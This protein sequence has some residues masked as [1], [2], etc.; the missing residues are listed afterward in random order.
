MNTSS[1]NQPTFRIREA[2]RSDLR[3]LVALER[4]LFGPGAWPYDV[5]DSELHADGRHY[6]VATERGIGPVGVED[7][8]RVIGYGGIAISDVGEIM[9]IGVTA[10]AQGRG[11][12]R[13]LTRALIEAAKA[14]GV[15]EVFLE[16]RVDNS[17]AINL[18][19]SLGFTDVRVR[20]GYYQ[21]ENIDALV[22]RRK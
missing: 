2:V 19:R 13:A 16:V 3:A 15:D 21:P 14:G 9:T 11:I 4:E 8:E 6:I 5:L 20:R 12:G 22:M 17:A 10:S 7:I 18:Y 1:A